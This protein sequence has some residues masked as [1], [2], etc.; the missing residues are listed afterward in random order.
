MKKEIG[1]LSNSVV[2]LQYR[3]QRL[4]NQ[5]NSLNHSDPVINTHLNNVKKIALQSMDLFNGFQ[6]QLNFLSNSWKDFEQRENL[7]LQREEK[8]KMRELRKNRRFV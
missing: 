1:M 5:V 3:T 6:R 7:K 2:D 8:E 4:S